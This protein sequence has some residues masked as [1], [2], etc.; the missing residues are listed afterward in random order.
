[1]S[2]VD[3]VE[4]L[5]GVGP[6]VSKKLAHLKIH[7][8][9]DLITNY[10][11]RYD[12]YSVIKKTDQTKPGE[13]VT[14]RGQIKSLNSRYVRRG[15]HITEGVVSDEKGSLK[16]VWFNQPY[17]SGAIKSGQTYLVSGLFEFTGRRLQI[18]NPSAEL[19]SS[20]PV[21]TARIVPIYKETKGLR[22]STIRKIISEIVPAIRKVNDNLPENITKDNA[23]MSKSD[24]VLNMH[25][26]ESSEALDKAKERLGFEEL[27]T[28]TLASL[29]NKKQ[30]SKDSGVKIDF[31]ESLAKDFASSLPYKLTNAQ[32]KVIWQVYQDIQSKTP[33]NRLIEG[34]VGSGKTV[35]AVMSA[36]MALKAG[37]QVALMAPTEILASQHH[38]SVTKMLEDTEFK[39]QSIKLLGNMKPAEKKSA[40]EQIKSGKKRLIVGTHALITENVDMHNLGLVIIDEQHRFGV[41]QRKTLMKKTRRTSLD[42]VQGTKEDRVN[43]SKSTKSERQTQTDAVMSQD[44]IQKS[45]FARVEKVESSDVWMPHVLSMTATPIPRTL[46]LTVFGELDI[47]VLDEMPPGRTPIGTKIVSP[48]SKDKMYREIE[49]E[50]ESGRQA[51]VVCPLIEESDVIKVLS[52]EQVY[53]TLSQKVF[54]NY[55]VALLH[56]K[57]K[58]AEKDK[59]MQDFVEKKIDILVSTTVVEVG[60]DVPN[61]TVMMIEGVERFGLAQ[62]HQLRGRVG[63]GE[64]PG[65][66]YLVMSDSKVPSRRIKAMEQ[67][68]DGF[69]L[70]ELDLEIRGPGALYG[71]MQS[72]LLDLRVANLSDSKLIAQAR[73]S[74]R[75]FIESNESLDKYPILKKQVNKYRSITSLN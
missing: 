28:L 56:G 59:V 65:K 68:S 54:K 7:T 4:T 34:D 21:N 48:N 12:D 40:Q 31:N 3:S 9:A 67:T 36:I 55:K 10:P 52:A 11:R 51:F 6:A 29:L 63:R 62:L 58:Q 46:A 33:M 25:F 69:R 73:N 35:V 41:E 27:F 43:R 47:S 19:E 22:S 75:I 74:A 30:F 2:P 57:L 37:Y 16:I 72:G 32:R 44:Q 8:I 60:V 66:C 26:P 42:S 71:A 50:L 45:G 14:L 70:A 38:D 5:K 61:A 15:L 18:T 1:M 23:L 39:N 64:Y 24:A 20:F 49:S 53:K 17:R 13:R